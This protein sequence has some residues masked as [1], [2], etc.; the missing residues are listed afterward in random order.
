MCRCF[1]SNANSKRRRS[2]KDNWE[3]F[4]WF[5]REKEIIQPFV[6]VIEKSKKTKFS[7]LLESVKLTTT[8]TVKVIQLCNFTSFVLIELF[9][10]L[11]KKIKQKYNIKF[12]SKCS[13]QRRWPYAGT[14]IF[15]FTKLLPFNYSFLPRNF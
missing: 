2:K 9:Y 7:I 1:I 4:I 5:A 8:Q 14:L 13:L 6:L 3:I 10:F 15:Y 12:L 11:N